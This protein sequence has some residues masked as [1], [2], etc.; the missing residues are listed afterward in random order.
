MA[1]A[2]AGLPAV[3]I[4]ALIIKEMDLIK[5]RWLVVGVVFIAATMMLQVRSQ[6]RVTPRNSRSSQRHELVEVRQLLNLRCQL[7]LNYAYIPLSFVTC[8]TRLIAT[9]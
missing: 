2:I 9:T 8:A 6:E 4:A 1:L 5:V 3:L 7:S